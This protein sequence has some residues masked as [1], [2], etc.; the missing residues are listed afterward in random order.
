MWAPTNKSITHS[1]SKGMKWG[2][3][4]GDSNGKRTA[5]ITETKGDG[6][7]TSVTQI[8]GNSTP[9]SKDA[10]AFALAKK[11][12]EDDQAAKKKAEF[13]SFIK[14]IG[15]TANNAK[16]VISKSI[17]EGESFINDIFKKIKSL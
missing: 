15:D 1:G 4:Y 6:P 11:K 17:S 3:T 7:I 2:Y 12:W 5:V 9:I 14:S 8:G 16:D 10:I 13:D